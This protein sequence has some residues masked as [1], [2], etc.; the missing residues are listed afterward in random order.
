MYIDPQSL[1]I[2]VPE[3]CGS[4]INGQSGPADSENPSAA[5]DRLA[6]PELIQKGELGGSPQADPLGEVAFL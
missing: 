2:D 6:H 4:Q 5:S 1:E 3:T